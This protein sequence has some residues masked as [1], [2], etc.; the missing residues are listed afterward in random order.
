MQI[1]YK[2]ANESAASGADPSL[3]IEE[4][5]RRERAV[6]WKLDCFIA[7]VMMLL[8]LISYLDRGNICISIFYIFYVLAE[9]PTSLL[10]KRLQYN[11]VI[12]CI[13]FCWG[14]VCMCTG[15][16][17]GFPS[18]AVTRLLLGFFEG[19]LFP[20]MT[21]F[22][23]DWYKREEL[24]TRISFLFVASAL[25]GAFG[26]L[27]AYAILYMDGVAGMS[28]W[29]WLYIIEGI[30]TLGWAGICLFVV[31]KNYETAYFL[32]EQDKVIMRCR[33][34]AT[35][36]YSGGQGHYKWK[37]IKMAAKD[38][39]SWIHG[40]IQIC[41]VTILY[42]FGTFLPIILKDGF[43][44]S[45]IQAQY[46]VIPVNLWGAIVYGVGAVLSDKYKA[47]FLSLI[48]SA[49]F[50][51]AGYAILVANSRHTMQPGIRYFATYL[52]STA[53][54][55]CTGTNIA[56]LSSNCAP[57][58][59]RAASVGILL[60]LTNIG[61]IVAGQIY[62]TNSAPGFV[63][64]HSWSLGCLAFAWCGWWV[65][66]GIYKQRERQ[67]DR[68]LADGNADVTGADWSDRAPD[69]RYQF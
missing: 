32:N 56:W 7:P 28:G 54:Y 52:I 41:V 59:K 16:V 25:S 49:P 62:Q 58:G 47:R 19:C 24:A 3:S 6:V 27:L 26:G 68:A 39:K 67:K 9:F 69:F 57:D 44:Y 33:A 60:T 65:V 14:L 40:V 11:R 22:L 43:H 51:I 29:R 50:G 36:A 2:T 61:G 18:L 45:T 31:P 64:G 48:I 5:V 35:A 8:M 30:I 21:L 34:E 46:L 20:S 12:P 63:L 37:D 13:T 42:G 15:F 4:Y 10:V 38:V 53:C 1:E 55:L 66:L 17:Q 23:C